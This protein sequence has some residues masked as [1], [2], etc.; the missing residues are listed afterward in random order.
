M[1]A[2]QRRAAIAA[3]VFNALV[4]G[5]SWWPFR[6]L[7]TQGLHGLWATSGI[8][9]VAALA[10]EIARPGSFA[11]ARRTPSL[12]LLALS[13]G[14][15]NACFNWAVTVGE[16]VRVV[17][18]FYLMPAWAMLFARWLLKERLNGPALLRTALAFAGAL[19][20]LWPADGD[21][22]LPRGLADWLAI[23]GGA[24]FAMNN[25]LLRRDAERPGAV[26][27]IAMF[28]G[29]ALVPAVV[30]SLLALS[31]VIPWPPAPELRWMGGL[32]VLSVAFIAGN[33]ALQHGASRL[34]ASTTAVVMLTEVVF[35][36]AS[37]VLLAG[38][39]L[40]VPTVAGG[41]MIVLASAL[42]ALGWPRGRRG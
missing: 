10:M 26:R 24:A 1:T 41:T 11:Q 32:A 13:G 8:Y 17:L 27:A 42:A 15:T 34:P 20:V 19:V 3:L 14:L 21:W 16:V 5:L 2:S 30:A 33:L 7:G 31:A 29:G 36:A 39:R 38:E 28:T 37:A 6:L 40:T 23:L 12:W 25:V 9:V 35:A 4:W 22:P 18:L